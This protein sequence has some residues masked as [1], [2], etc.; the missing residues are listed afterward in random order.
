M[1]ENKLSPQA[2]LEQRRA[3]RAW[4]C[5]KIIKDS[6]DIKKEFREGYAQ[7]A[8]GAPADIQTN[9]LGQTLAF[10]RARGSKDKFAYYQTLWTDLSVWL[11]TRLDMNGQDLLEWALANSSNYRRATAEA[12]AFLVWLKRFAEVEIPVHEGDADDHGS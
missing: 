7:A 9:G 5:V 3:L 11:N 12:I 2:S 1:A 4:G 10:W 6:S 8:R